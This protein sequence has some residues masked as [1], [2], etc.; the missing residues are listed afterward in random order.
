MRAPRRGAR[1]SRWRAGSPCAAPGQRR[2]PVAGDADGEHDRQR[3]HHLD[4][5]REEG[6]QEEKDVG[7]AYSA[8]I[9]A[10]K[11]SWQTRRLSFSVGVTSSSS[12]E[13]SRGSTANFLI[14]SK[15]ES[16]RLTSSTSA[17]IFSST[18]AR[19]TPS[20]SVTSAATYGRRSPT[21][22]ACEISGDVLSAFSRF[23]GATFLP[24]AV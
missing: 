24:P 13:K 8:S 22:S 21:T 6:R 19:G 3:L 11:C 10:A 20:S 17:W 7:H 14:C 5:A 9:S 2:P 1:R 16:S 18:P 12:A 15:R 4:G 23:C